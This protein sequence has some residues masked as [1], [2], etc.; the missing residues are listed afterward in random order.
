MRIL[1]LDSGKGLI[2]FIKQIIKKDKKNDYYLFMDHEYFPY[3]KKSPLQ[4]RRR[5]DFLLKKFEYL[6]I[7]LLLICC[8]TLSNIYLHNKY[9]V[10]YKVKTILETNLQHLKNKNILVTENL[11]KFYLK[12]QRFIACNIASAIENNEIENLIKEIKS[13]KSNKALILGCTHYS[14]AK[15]VFD[16]YCSFKVFTYEDEFIDKLKSSDNLKFFGRKYEIEIFKKYFP[17]NDIELYE[18]S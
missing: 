8:N 15:N 2:P 9:H 17:Q 7:D 18:L 10:T 14:L 5:L 16:H 4:L 6:H 13:L 1:L 11:K 3:G 12:D